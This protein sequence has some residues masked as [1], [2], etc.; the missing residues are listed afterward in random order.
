MCSMI[1]KGGESDDDV[2]TIYRGLDF[3]LEYFFEH[4]YLASLS[5]FISRTK[6]V[7][8][9]LL[10]NNPSTVELD[11]LLSGDKIRRETIVFIRRK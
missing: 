7:D 6:L 3:T 2:I 10:D 5:P 1:E 4:N 8:G 9:D 11:A